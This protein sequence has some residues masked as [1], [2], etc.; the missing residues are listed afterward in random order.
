MNEI[1]NLITQYKIRSIVITE[2]KGGTK[3]VFINYDKQPI[4]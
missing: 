3:T 4:N 2:S 1:Y